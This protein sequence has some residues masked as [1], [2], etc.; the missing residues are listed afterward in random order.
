MVN[1][2]KAIPMYLPSDQAGWRKLCESVLAEER[3]LNFERFSYDDA[4]ALGSAMATNA[5]SKALPVAI[6]V[7]FGEQR[8]FHRALEGASATNDDW[9]SR[10]FRAVA[11]H[12]CSSFALVCKERGDGSDYFQDGGY[13][14]ATIAVAGGA[15]PLRVRGS[16]IGAVGV[17]GLAGEDDHQFVVDALIGFRSR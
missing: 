13:D 10:K 12:R 2:R 9:L 15:V 5:L 11:K 1:D 17:S 14:R 16:I 8:V 4:W 6:A 7:E 3:S